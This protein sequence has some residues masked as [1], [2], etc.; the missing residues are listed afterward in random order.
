MGGTLRADR[1]VSILM[2]LQSRGRVPARELAETLGVSV[3][4]IYRDM[5]ALS[6]SGIPVYTERG[7]DGGCCL[8]EN[9]R[10]DLTGLNED[11]AHAL[12]L[13][14][15]PG[16]LDSLE[17]GQ[18]MRS[19]LR[20]LAAALPGYLDNP[21]K[22]SPRV[23]L[24]W[25]AWGSPLSPG[26]HLGVLYRAIQRKERVTLVYP[27]WGGIEIEQLAD[28]LG[29]VA[30]SGDWFL[31]WRSGRKLRWQRVHE[32]QRVTPTGQ[33]FQFPPGFD[34]L[35]A[36]QDY[37]AGWDR[38]QA[39]Y[40]VQA[41]VLPEVIGDLRRRPGVTVKILEDVPDSAGRLL[42]EMAFRSLEA[43][44]QNL[45]GLGCGVKVLS[46]GP[47]RLGIADFARQI[48]ELYQDDGEPQTRGN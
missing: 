27:M 2:L 36:W 24:D 14:T 11:E 20:K 17:V 4:T 29:L 31:I 9:Y 43:A 23:H 8:V 47:L 10:S 25:T 33:H 6:T 42:L 5:D 35:A 26:E 7:V 32:L 1:L 30:K 15:A 44:R 19:A 21:E 41:R 34:L 38:D 16:P 28:P 12:F 18:K 37:C 22:V 39:L 40:L 46:P 45:M 48:V 3:R 13:L